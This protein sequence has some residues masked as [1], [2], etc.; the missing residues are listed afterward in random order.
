MIAGPEVSV[1][2][3]NE[4]SAFAF[5]EQQVAFGPRVSGSAANLK[6]AR[7]LHNKLLTYTPDVITQ[8]AVVRL[9]NGKSV[10]ARNIIASF[11]SHSVVRILLCSHWDSR[12]YADY[13][14]DSTRHRT[15]IDGANDGAS[16]VGVL[17]ETARI[18]KLNKVDIGVDIV[19]FD[20]EDY[21]APQDNQNKVSEDDW[22]LGSQ[23]WSRNPHKPG[24]KARF[25]IL[26][27]M[28]G[29]PGAFFTKEGISMQYAPD[30]VSKV[31]DAA[32]RSGYGMYFSDQQTHPITDDH[33]Y[34]NKLSGI[35]TIDIIHY[36][37]NS[38]TG[39]YKNWHTSAD[40]L[41]NI[42][43]KALKAVGQTLLTVI[44]EEAR[45]PG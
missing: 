38:P 11:N 26:L 1:P 35:P 27:D 33:Y 14:P 6:C 16:G 31:W 21:G 40:N 10:T 9:Y 29:V 43:R 20:A 24:Y 32:R 17:L 30:V 18:L 4:D 12:P 19:L 39:F 5:V 44:F 7:W 15:P 2:V 13:D 41:E 42:D 34:I 22:G 23:Y 45:P 25:G 28:V 36:D 37:N 8:E 3:F